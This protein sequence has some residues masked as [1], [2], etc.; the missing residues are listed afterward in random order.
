[1]LSFRIRIACLALLGG[2]PVVALSEPRNVSDGEIALLPVYCKDKEWNGGSVETYRKERWIASLGNSWKGVHHYCWA[3]VNVR[4]AMLT[5]AN[6]VQRKYLIEVAVSDYFFAIENSTAEFLVLPEI[7]LRLGE[8]YELLNQPAAAIK[9][10]ENAIKL[11]P[12]YWPAYQ[13]QAEVLI[14]LKLNDRA[15]QVV[16]EGLRAVAEQPELLEL[17]KRLGA[18]GKE[19]RGAPAKPKSVITEATATLKADPT[20]AGKR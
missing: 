10:Y 7:H 3:L 1:M 17:S 14:K 18:A 19:P 12:D 8:A 15:K 20:A 4:R 6:P 2:V 11:K 5:A 13:R 9:A 16:A